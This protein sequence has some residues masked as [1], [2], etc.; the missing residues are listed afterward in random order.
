M[1]SGKECR[2]FMWCRPCCFELLSNTLIYYAGNSFPI[3]LAPPKIVNDRNCLLKFHP[4]KVHLQ[5][6]RFGNSLLHH[7]VLFDGLIFGN[8]ALVL[9][10][11]FSTKL[12]HVFPERLGGLS[13][14]DL[15]GLSGHDVWHVAPW[16]RSSKCRQDTPTQTGLWVSHL[17]VRRIPLDLVW[18]N[19]DQKLH[20]FLV[21][22]VWKRIVN[23]LDNTI[24]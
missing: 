19:Q 10:W 4:S 12:L 11:Q 8:A 5:F 17:D 2:R 20:V 21:S 7:L 15:A 14:I 22:R 9:L 23:Q 24:L 18:A 13:V 3:F 6:P 16:Q 1:H